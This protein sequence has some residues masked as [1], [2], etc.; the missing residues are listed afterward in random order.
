[1]SECLA[2]RP[3][4]GRHQAPARTASSP[5]FLTQMVI[6]PVLPEWLMLKM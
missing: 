2:G 5:G 4:T 1:M 6:M 3:V